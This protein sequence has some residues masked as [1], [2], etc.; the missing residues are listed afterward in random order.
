MTAQRVDAIDATR[1]DRPRAR[2]GSAR[3]ARSAR[4]KSSWLRVLRRLGLRN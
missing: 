2:H 3:S 4:S 1:L